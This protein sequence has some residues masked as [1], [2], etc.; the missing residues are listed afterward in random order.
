MSTERDD[1]LLALE[2][3]YGPECV[4]RQGGDSLCVHIPDR[5]SVPRMD[6]RITLPTTYP[7]LSAPVVELSCRL[8]DDEAVASLAGR[9]SA[10]FVPGEVVL[11]AWIELLREEWETI[12]PPQ[13]TS[14]ASG[15]AQ[16]IADALERVVPLQQDVE[17]QGA[18]ALTTAPQH[19]QA[20]EM[21]QSVAEVCGRIVHGHAV[22]EKRSTFQ[23]HLAPIHS[24]QQAQAVVEC[25]MQNN[26]VRAASHNIQAYRIERADVP[27]N[28]LQ[29]C[30]DDGE[31]AAGGRL[32]H[33]L[34]L[35]DARNVMVVVSR[36]FGG[37]HLGPARFALINNVARELLDECGFIAEK[38]A[39]RKGRKT[40]R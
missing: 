5:S 39:S 14:N 19:G 27:G 26:K 24:V 29:D 22:T 11:F 30:D 21:E 16:H 36:W 17:E 20:A 25:L 37:I 32:L 9:L 40:A 8:L 2:A 34:Q 6:V 38:Q 33:L 12:P 18:G 1:E 4:L 13:P 10:L 28:F 7:T 23:A 35:L 31:D 15:E 3:I